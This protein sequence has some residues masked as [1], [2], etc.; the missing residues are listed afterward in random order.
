MC[1][2]A[3][4]VY[5]CNFTKSG[6]SYEII[7][8]N[9]QNC[10]A[11]TCT[12]ANQ[13]VGSQW[14]TYQDLAGDPPTTIANHTVP[15]GIKPVLLAAGVGNTGSGN[16]PST[17]ILNLPA[18]LP[19]NAQITAGYSGSDPASY[20][21]WS[22]TPVSQIPA[23]SLSA[24]QSVISRAPSASF[25]TTS[26][27][28]NLGSQP[29]SLGPYLVTLTV[30]DSN[31]NQSAPAQAYVTLVPSDLS[32]VRVFPNPWRS[33][34]HGGLMVTFDNLSVNSSIK[35]FTVSGHWIKTLPTSSTS[36][37]WDLTNDSGDKV[38][39]GL[40]VYLIR[41]DQGQ[42]KTGQLAVIK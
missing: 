14:T 1:S 26:P 27:S 31:G 17:P 4:T 24:S 36:V 11:G 15:V 25:T 18:F 41:D 40:Y 6:T 7:W 32:G 8:D 34:K 10:S 38:A 5:T 16:T 12:T 2:N 42:K 22:F 28:A 20:F 39:S 9:S 13:T 3:G 29:L 35:I 37:T 21:S 33:D 19:I 30:Y 23:G